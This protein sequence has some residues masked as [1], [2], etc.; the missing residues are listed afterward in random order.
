LDEGDA[1]IKKIVGRQLRLFE[2]FCI[3]NRK[4]YITTAL[5]RSDAAYTRLAQLYNSE[6]FSQAEQ[7]I[8]T[9]IDFFNKLV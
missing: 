1:I 9:V 4:I 8:V 5:P 6:L 2:Q 3:A 7:S